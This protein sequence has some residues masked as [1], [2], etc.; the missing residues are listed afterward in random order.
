MRARE[1]KKAIQDEQERLQVAAKAEIAHGKRQME[2]SEEKARQY[3]VT[4]EALGNILARD[5]DGSDDDDE[6]EGEQ[7]T[8]AKSVPQ[9]EDLK[10]GAPET[11]PLNELLTNGAGMVGKGKRAF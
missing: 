11:L 6:E 10:G 3:M 5:Q 8:P 9:R 7:S 1:W 4:A 2:A